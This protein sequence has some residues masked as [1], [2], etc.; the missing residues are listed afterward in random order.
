MDELNKSKKELDQL[1]ETLSKT[2]EVNKH[3]EKIEET[4]KTREN[5]LEKDVQE[6]LRFFKY[7]VSKMSLPVYSTSYFIIR[8]QKMG[9]LPMTKWTPPTSS[10]MT[11]L[12]Q[13]CPSSTEVTEATEYYLFTYLP[14]YRK[15][16]FS[17]P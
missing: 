7:E 4:F 2:S 14:E 3:L 13:Y 15:I 17:L 5:K 10:H 8:R 11:L 1:K 16:F 9:S 6:K 12:P